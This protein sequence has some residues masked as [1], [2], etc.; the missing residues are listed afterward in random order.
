M[1]SCKLTLSNEN[2]P[3]FIFVFL[4]VSSCFVFKSDIT[5]LER[6]VGVIMGYGEYQKVVFPLLLVR[7]SR[8]VEPGFV[9]EAI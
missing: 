3:A 8:N 6:C 1:T 2:I 5:H 7:W 9:K 4:P